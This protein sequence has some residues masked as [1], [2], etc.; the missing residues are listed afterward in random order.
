[1]QNDL[2]K[3]DEISKGCLLLADPSIINDRYFNRSVVL[4]TEKNQDEIV[5]FILNKPLEFNFHDIFKGL[6]KDFIIYNGGPVNIDNVYYIHNI[7]DLIDNSLKISKDLFW[8]G[9]F[10]DIKK[11]IKEKKIGVNN[12]RFF[13]GYSGWTL[14]QLNNEIKEK[15]WVITNNRFNDKILESNSNEFWK[16]EIKKLGNEYIIWSNAP[17]NPKLN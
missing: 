14:S 1:M 3:L 17:E 6:G 5:G 10:S 11:L 8:G 12:I 16:N 4:I 2:R 13:S 15:S 9:N 7:P